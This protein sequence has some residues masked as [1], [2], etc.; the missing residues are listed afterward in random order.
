MVCCFSVAEAKK[1]DQ[2]QS[3]RTGIRARSL[4]IPFEGKPGTHNAITDVPGVLV[5]HSTI[6][7]GKGALV[8][9]KGP[10]RTGVTAIL[11][12]GKKFAPVTAGWFAL[13]GEGE[14]TGTA[15]IDNMGCLDT[16]ICITDTLAIGEVHKTM[17]RWIR[18][19]G[20]Y[21][22]RDPLEAV[23]LVAE[24]WSA[25]LNDMAGLHVKPRHV[26]AALDGAKGG[27]VAEGAVGGG[28]GMRAFQFKAGIGTSSRVLSKKQGG[29]K[30][31]VLVQANF[32]DR[33]DLLVAGAPVGKELQRVALPIVHRPKK[34]IHNKDQGSCVVV[35]ATDAPLQPHQLK[36]LAMRASLGMARTGNPAHWDSGEFFL[37]FS[38]A[39]PRAH[40]AAQAH[41]LDALPQSKMDPICR[42]AMEATEEAIINSLV[43]AKTTDGVNGNVFFG[44]PHDKLK[45]A[46]AKY[47][48][49][50]PTKRK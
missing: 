5:G 6:R 35:V 1:A 12:R 24:T 7:S 30:V 8:P 25:D 15:R 47:N 3:Q 23:P 46:L 41:K 36:A 18:D 45:E 43:A 49:L 4:G 21:D 44:I 13:N 28:T 38:T 39:N 22:R 9:G 50:L 33:Q 26:I 19:N 37:A 17:V 11:P 16:P 2:A 48:R 14:M 10:V 27:P 40:V 31:G 32:G 34:T 42:A 20:L 29:Y